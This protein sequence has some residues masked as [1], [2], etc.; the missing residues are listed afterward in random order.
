MFA[1]LSFM[2]KEKL[3]FNN[4]GWKKML[5]MVKAKKVQ[6]TFGHL[7]V[8]V[9]FGAKDKDL[10]ISLGGT[11]RRVMCQKPCNKIPNYQFI[12][13]VGMRLQTKMLIDYFY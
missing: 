2:K 10:W 7:T 1:I 9:S 8:T 6:E 4:D 3:P 12:S 11:F 5:K 13:I